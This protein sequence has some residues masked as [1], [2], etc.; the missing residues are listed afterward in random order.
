MNMPKISVIIPV[1]NVEKYIER[2]VRSLLEQTLSDIEYIFVNDGSTDNSIVLLEKII[3]DYPER[4]SQVY[5]LNQVNEGVSA[6]RNKGLKIAKGDYVAFCDSDDWVSSDMYKTLYDRAVLFKAEVIYCDFY[7]YYGEREA[8]VYKTIPITNNK[9]DFLRSYMSSYTV[10][11]NMIVKRDLYEKYKLCFPTHI[12]YREDFYLSVQIYYYAAKVEK[13]EKPLYF[14]NRLNFNSALYNRSRREFNDELTCDLDIISF[15]T[16]EGVIGQYI[17]KLSW[18]VL[19]D[20]QTLVLDSNKHNEFLSIY[21]ESHKYIW[22]C[23]YINKKI[24]IMMWLLVHH[25][26]LLVRI[27]NRIRYIISR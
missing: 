2:C 1:Y 10:L 18:G 22:S 14:Y 9:V 3:L 24:K 26:G 27:I 16:K 7:M 5:I 12:R 17:D 8:K 11:W 6:A 13:I 21:P 25:L 4:S 23:P 19:R 15:F 20:K